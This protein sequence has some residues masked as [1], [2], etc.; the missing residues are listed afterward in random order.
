MR[1]R[2]EIFIAVARAL[3]ELKRATWRRVYELL[4]AKGLPVSMKAVRKAVENMVLHGH[5]VPVADERVPWSRRPMKV[6]T[7]PQPAIQSGLALAEVMSA[8]G[9]P[10]HAP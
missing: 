4:V 8:W 9:R 6:Y 5:L 3:D 2:G 7:T 1:P 10:M